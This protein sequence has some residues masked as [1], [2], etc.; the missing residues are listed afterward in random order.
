MELSFKDEPT[1]IR[2]EV[3][4]GLKE[5]VGRKAVGV[6]ELQIELLKEA[7]DEAIEVLTALS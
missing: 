4:K 2:C 3:E 7:G 5:T 6:D 1:V